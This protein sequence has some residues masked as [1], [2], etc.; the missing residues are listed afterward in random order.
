[1]KIL[2]LTCMISLFGC[3]HTDQEH[4]SVQSAVPKAPPAPAAGASIEAKEVAAEEQDPFVTEF[5]FA[6]GKETLAKPD[7]LRLKKFIEEASRHGHITDVKVVSWSDQEYPSVNTKRLAKSQIELANARADNIE[8]QVRE[9]ADG[10]RVEKLNMAE[11]PKMFGEWLGTV[12][13]RIKKSLEVAGIPNT[14]T[15]VKTPAKASRAI[16]LLSLRQ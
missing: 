2:F 1:M 10:V 14:D 16:V 13:A 9:L 12:D 4:H 7:Q 6:K 11:R 8:S 3:A 15:S 5:R